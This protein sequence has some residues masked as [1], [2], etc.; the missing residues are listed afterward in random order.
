MVP[1]L[2]IAA[3]LVAVIIDPF[4]TITE[5][6]LQQTIALLLTLVTLLSTMVKEEPLIEESVFDVP[7]KFATTAV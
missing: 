7:Y 5:V 2:L 1:L 4:S 6:L 3:A